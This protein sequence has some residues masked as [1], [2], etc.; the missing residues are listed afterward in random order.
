MANDLLLCNVRPMAQTATN[1]LIRNG[2]IAETGAVASANGVE[3]IDGQGTI[4][5]P[6]PGRSAYPSR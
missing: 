4:L 6:G 5:I 1:I 2:R 3:V